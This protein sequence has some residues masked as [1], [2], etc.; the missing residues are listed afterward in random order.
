MTARTS[1]IDRDGRSHF[2][3]DR[4]RRDGCELQRSKAGWSLKVLRTRVGL[5]LGTT[6]VDSFIKSA[7]PPRSSSVREQRD[8]LN[9]DTIYDRDEALQEPQ[10]TLLPLIHYAFLPRIIMVRILLNVLYRPPSP[11]I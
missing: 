7:K 5:L 6:R 1:R 2:F 3:G 11:T 9:N 8:M 4:K 10:A